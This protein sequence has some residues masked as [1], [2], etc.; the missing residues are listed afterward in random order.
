MHS[1][2]HAATVVVDVSYDPQYSQ[3]SDLVVL[4]SF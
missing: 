1:Q 4:G 2:D 3:L